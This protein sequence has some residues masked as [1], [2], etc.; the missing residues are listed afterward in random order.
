MAGGLTY[1]QRAVAGWLRGNVRLVQ[2]RGGLTHCPGADL[3]QR[4]DKPLCSFQGECGGCLTVRILR[5]GEQHFP[6]ALVVVQ[7]EK[8]AVGGGDPVVIHGGQCGVGDHVPSAEGTQ[9]GQTAGS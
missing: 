3:V 9:G 5:D 7:G 6:A 8:A 4:V 2:R 1:E